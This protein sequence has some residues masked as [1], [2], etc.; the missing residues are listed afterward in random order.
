M[1][2][3][4]RALRP[5]A[6]SAGLLEKRV[7]QSNVF[8]TATSGEDQAGMYTHMRDEQALRLIAVYA[9]VRILADQIA[10]LPFAAFQD[11]DNGAPMVLP[12]QPP[13][14]ANPGGNGTGDPTNFEFWYQMVTSLALTGNAYAVVM[15]RD[16][17]QYPLQLFPVHPYAVEIS[18]N[19]EDGKADYRVG[20]D[21]I[22][23]YDM[24]HIKRFQLAG[25][26]T[27]TSPI[28]VAA[29]GIGLGLSSERFGARYFVDSAAPSS[30]LES[31][32]NIPPDNAKGIIQNWIATHG[33]RRYPAILSG[34]LKYRQIT[35]SPNEAQFLE[36][37]QFQRSEIAMLF[38]IPPHMIGDVERST[39]WGTGIEQQSTGFL[40]YNLRPWLVCLEHAFNRL[41]PRGQFCL[42]DA[43]ALLR[44]DAKTRWESYE[45]GR[46]AGALSVNDILRKEAMPLIG[47]EGDMRLQPM[48]YVPLGTKP[49][50]YPAVLA[51]EAAQGIDPDTGRPYVGMPTSPP[52][53][54]PANSPNSNGSGR[55]PV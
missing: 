45:A 44:G 35:I 26:L 28:G 33:G 39:S 7:F 32:I 20:H 49:D 48:N 50:E 10:S 38:G 4:S 36:T 54:A 11:D 25:K 55:V 15:R 3:I 21:A 5:K 16:W 23:R 37:R 31:D 46:R 24:L 19:P 18:R 12:S 43:D 2:L 27:G 34:G 9:C 52:P 8:A 13:V 42:F 1:S 51:A 22:P 6:I 29:Q 41:T 14:I 40:I 53:Q 47:P 30:V 17:R